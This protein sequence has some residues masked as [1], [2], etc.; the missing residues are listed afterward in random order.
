M[1]FVDRYLPYLRQWLTICT[2]WAL[3]LSGLC[4]LKVHMEIS[5]LLFLP[6]LVH[7]QHSHPLCCVIVFSSLFVVHF[8]NFFSVCVGVVQS[9]QGFMLVYPMGGWGKTA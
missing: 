4:L 8:F 2:L 7:F 1:S 3:L 9:A 6:S 5:S